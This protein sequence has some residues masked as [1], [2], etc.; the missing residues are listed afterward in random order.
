MNFGVGVN[1]RLINKV[2]SET[3]NGETSFHNFSEA[4]PMFYATAL[5]DLPF[6]GLS[7]GFEGLHSELP[8]NGRFDYKA[9][10]HYQWNDVLGFEGGWQHQQQPFTAGHNDLQETEGADSLYLDFRLNF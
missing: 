4:I 5:F 9:K 6:K 7:A 2:F 3:E 1:I 10:L 8:K